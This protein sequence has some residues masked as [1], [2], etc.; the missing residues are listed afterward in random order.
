MVIF[1]FIGVR[2]LERWKFR[3]A[4]GHN[5]LC[6]EQSTRVSRSVKPC[7]HKMKKNLYNCFTTEHTTS[8]IPLL[9]PLSIPYFCSKA[10]I[11]E[12]KKFMM[13]QDNGRLVIP[14]LVVPPSQ[15]RSIYS[16]KSTRSG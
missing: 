5:R 3:V 13:I 15:F 2:T 16:P 14:A 9:I 4:I 6:R 11:S 1:P 10:S 12:T 8:G 7:S